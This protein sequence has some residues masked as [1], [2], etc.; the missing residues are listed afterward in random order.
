M[1]HGLLLDIESPEYPPPPLLLHVPPAPTSQ[2][3]PLTCPLWIIPCDSDKC[4]KRILI[5]VWKALCMNSIFL[6]NGT[7]SHP[8]FFPSPPW[9]SLKR[10]IDLIW[11][12]TA[13]FHSSEVYSAPVYKLHVV[14]PSQRPRSKEHTCQSEQLKTTSCLNSELTFVST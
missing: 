13:N 7:L 6:V 3:P 1:S 12:E 2:P 14:T 11:E 8:S 5:Y 9:F 4:I 10:K